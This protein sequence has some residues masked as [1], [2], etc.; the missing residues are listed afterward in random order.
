MTTLDIQKF[1][2]EILGGANAEILGVDPDTLKTAGAGAGELI[3]K[4]FEMGANKVAADKAKAQAKASE[5]DVKRAQDARNEA[6][7]A[8]MRATAE[9]DPVG[10]LHMAALD[11]E[12]KARQLEAKVGITAGPMVPYGQQ[13]SGE[14]PFS[15]K[16]GGLPVY[17]WLL[18]GA[19][20][21]G[22]IALLAHMLKSK[23]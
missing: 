14:N 16:V 22:V 18:V 11:A 21:I 13:P 10:P 7:K 23:K 20:G 2:A 6:N 3:S 19:G 4:A 9:K 8:A 5:G 1:E 15:K 12:T 17:G